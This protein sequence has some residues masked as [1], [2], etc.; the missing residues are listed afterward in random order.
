MTKPGVAANRDAAT[1]K[2]SLAAAAPND[3]PAE[4]GLRAAEQAFE[5]ATRLGRQQEAGRAGAWACTHEMRLGRHRDVLER[6]RTVLPLLGELPELVPE[7]RELLRCVALCGSESGNFDRALEAAQELAS[8]VASGNADSDARLTAAYALA[9]CLER[10]GDA[11]QAERLLRE[12]LEADDSGRASRPLL[13]AANGLCA[14][15]LGIAHRLRGAGS[16]DEFV[17]TLAL[18]RRHAEQA[19][20]LLGELPDPLYEIAVLGNLSEVMLLQGEGAAAQPLLQHALAGAQA[21]GAQAH[22]WRIRVSMADSLLAL[23]RAAEAR[24]QMQRQLA[25]M[26]GAAPIQTLIRAHFTAYRAAR[27]LADPA[28][29]LAHLEAAE[30]LDRARTTNQ[31]RVQS[32]LFVTRAEAQRAREQTELARADA[33]RHRERA[34]E[35]AD[36]AERDPL[37]GLG[38]RRH[39]QRR[40]DELLPALARDQEPL[41]LAL[42]DLDHFKRVNDEHGHAAGDRVLQEVAQLLRENTRGRDVVVRQGGEE[43]LVMLPGMGEA[44]AHEACERL[45]E[46]IESHAWTRLNKPGLQVTVSIGLASAPPHE[47]QPL[48]LRADEALYRAKREGRNRLAVG[49]A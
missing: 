4:L 16:D 25:E 19:R 32:E 5:L 43:F 34:A 7:K 14:I 3:Q 13:L 21:M 40:C 44:H 24:D 12:A 35:L 26:A 1:L 45:R 8:S 9:V 27:A 33:R 20:A 29:A 38:N 15:G 23:G 48:L 41:S 28:Q 11:W 30:R 6:S 22:A 18:A 31:L 47:F 46:C 49:G 42:L 39:L 37:T 17:A 10:M 36:K 2:A